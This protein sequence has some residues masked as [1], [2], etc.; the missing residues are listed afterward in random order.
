MLLVAAIAAIAFSSTP[1]ITGSAA[2]EDLGGPPPTNTSHP[3]PPA[4][5]TPRATTAN[6][7]ATLTPSSTTALSPTPDAI[8][9]IDYPDNTNP[10][11]GLPYPNLEARQRRN[12]IVKV[13]NYTPVVRPQSGLSEA[14]IVWEYEV[15]G[16]VTRF[17]AIYRSQGSDHVGSVRSARLL[18]FELVSTY[19]AILAYSGSNDNIKTMILQGSCIKPDSGSRT[20]CTADP[21]LIK[22]NPWHYQAMTP[23]F[24]DN[25]PPFCRFPRPGLAFEH[26]LFGNTF[27]MWDLAT[28]RNINTGTATKGMSFTQNPDPGGKPAVDIA[29][30]WYHDQDARWQYNPADGKY[31]RWNSGLPHMDADNGQQLSADNVI[32]VQAT[33]LNRP[34]IFEYEN[35]SPAVEIQ[36]WGA[37]KAYLFRDGQWYQGIWRRN[38]DK[39]GLYFYYPDNKTPLHLKPG[40]TW[41]EV[42]RPEMSGVKVSTDLIDVHGTETPAAMAATANAPHIPDPN[43]TQTA[44]VAQRTQAASM[45]T[46]GIAT[47]TAAP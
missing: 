37:D 43:L 45:A 41:I 13:S 28:K 25:C 24:G 23:Q 12:L 33:H 4:T 40:N 3:A 5:N 8:G 22:A 44:V 1:G 42:V 38:H 32:I 18:D 17:A 9:P 20:P 19:N 14:D 7:T 47:P 35:G 11:T 39:G 2:S 29:I 10:L 27:Q 36:L 46:A 30:K 31:Y 21:N 6:V 26:T 34:D 16:G 15:E